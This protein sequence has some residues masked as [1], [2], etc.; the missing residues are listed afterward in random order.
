M[1]ELHVEGLASHSDPESCVTPREVR[2]EALT[3]ALVGPAIEPRK[4]IPVADT[5]TVA[6]RQ[7]G[8]DR[9]RE[10]GPEPAGSENRGMSGTFKHYTLETSVVAGGDGRPVRAGKGQ[11]HTPAMHAAE[12]S[13]EGVVPMKP[14]NKGNEM[15]A[16]VVEGRP[17]SS[18]NVGQPPEDGTQGPLPS[19][20]GL[21]RVREAAQRDRKQR[22]TSLMHH[23]TPALLMEAFES[24]RHWAAAGV[25]GVTWHDY[26]EERNRRI[27]DLHGRV[28]SGAYRAQPSRR[29]Y[30]P[31]PDGR[32]RPLGIAALEDKIVQKAT[33]WV[34]E[35]IYE[36]DFA[37]FSY[38]FRPRHSAQNAL[39]ALYV[40]LTERPVQWVVDADIKGF[41][42]AINH[43]WMMTFLEHRIADR[44]MLRMIAKWLRAGVNEDG[45]WKPGV[46]GTPQGAV[47]SPLLAN[48]YLHH[49][50]DLW[51]KWWRTQPQ[52]TGE[53]YI[54]RY[55]DDFVVGC[56]KR[57]EIPCPEEPQEF[58]CNANNAHVMYRDGAGKVDCLPLGAAVSNTVF[59]MKLS[60]A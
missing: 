51:V 32:Q 26:D 6:G 12:E 54:V 40:A 20:S 58:R 30:I 10:I 35:S 37:G 16:E 7:H 60:T 33:V 49:V 21:A 38:G 46:V 8:S 50:L 34:L 56:S 39:D 44:R 3:G 41:F 27:Q 14:P 2:G 1:R 59:S 13:D 36:G 19:W 4:F 43:Q 52:T 17:E 31:K 15:P 9:E 47:I 25:D 11:T 28:Q 45:E 55:A 24:L 42:D 48:V 53:V 57:S 23:I 18:G 5:V 29:T 22:F